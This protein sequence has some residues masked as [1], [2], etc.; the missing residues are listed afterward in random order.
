MENTREYM[1]NVQRRNENLKL[2]VQPVPQHEPVSP[3]MFEQRS[4]WSTS[5]NEKLLKAF[6]A[7]QMDVT[8]PKRTLI[9]KHHQQPW[10]ILT[11]TKTRVASN[12]ANGK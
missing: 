3:E 2:N 5:P 10:K 11:G 12:S 8:P 6:S 1:L 7:N 4:T 9:Q